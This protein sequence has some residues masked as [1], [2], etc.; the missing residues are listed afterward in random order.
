M[1]A[2]LINKETGEIFKETNQGNRPDYFLGDK[3]RP[4]LINDRMKLK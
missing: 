3:N 1:K 4:T 2:E